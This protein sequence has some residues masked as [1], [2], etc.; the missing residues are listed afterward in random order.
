MDRVQGSG[1]WTGSTG[2]VHGPRVHVLFSPYRLM[3][4]K[5]N[6]DN[7]IM[8]CSGDQNGHITQTMTLIPHLDIL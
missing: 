1:Q 4:H 2:V 7:D 6:N 3:R 5:S 8:M